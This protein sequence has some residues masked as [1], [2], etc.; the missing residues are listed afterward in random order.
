MGG[1]VGEQFLPLLLGRCTVAHPL[2][3]WA[4]GEPLLPPA[5]TCM[6]KDVDH[7]GTTNAFL[8]SLGHAYVE[9]PGLAARGDLS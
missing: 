7:T 2:G 9:A 1:Q 8:V 5:I 3:C 4:I 6:W